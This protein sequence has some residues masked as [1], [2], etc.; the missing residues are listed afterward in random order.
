MTLAWSV[1]SHYLNVDAPGKAK[2]YSIYWLI[3][4]GLFILILVEDHLVF[5]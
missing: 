2:F 4:Q 5:Y 3:F 1:A